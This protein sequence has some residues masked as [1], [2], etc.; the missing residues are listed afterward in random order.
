V[1]SFI[2][3]PSYRTLVLLLIFWTST[4]SVNWV[5]AESYI[6]RQQRLFEEE[7][8]KRRLVYNNLLEAAK[9]NNEYRAILFEAFNDL[10]VSESS[11]NSSLGICSET[12]NFNIRQC[13]DSIKK[14]RNSIAISK[15]KLESYF[16]S[17]EHKK[18]TDNIDENY[19]Y[20]FKLLID[21]L[22]FHRKSLNQLKSIHLSVSSHLLKT[23]NNSSKEEYDEI[24]RVSFC[25][26]S[27]YRLGRIYRSIDRD[28]RRQDVM[29]H[30]LYEAKRKLESARFI[31]D[32]KTLA[33][34]MSSNNIEMDRR[35]YEKYKT[36]LGPALDKSNLSK[37]IQNLCEK[38]KPS[39]NIEI[40]NACDKDVV[41]EVFLTT[42]STLYKKTKMG[43]K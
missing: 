41:N 25:K 6:K 19:K 26:D 28:L 9:K 24:N 27:G 29:P 1:Y 35:E 3:Y 17:L 12:K 8:S 42:L 7:E 30:R 22:Q 16:S 4:V 34:N 40:I 11:I 21:S 10:K 18:R 13:I 32:N 14:S 20:I 23:Y 39:L 2:K 37:I 36:V 15:A 5:Y 38:L 31:L 33:C 43:D